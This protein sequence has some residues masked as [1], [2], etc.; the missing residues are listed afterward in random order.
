[1]YTKN[2]KLHRGV[3]NTIQFQ[4]LNQDQKPINLTGFDINFRLISDD[5]KRILITKTVS[6]NPTD[7]ALP[8][9]GIA[10]LKLLDTDLSS[11]NAQMACYSL[12]IKT[13][14][15]ILAGL[16]IF[17]D[18]NSGARG[19]I[20]ILNSV[21]SDFVPSLSVSIPNHPLPGRNTPASFYS[22][23]FSPTT[24]AFTIQLMYEDYSG[25]M[26]VQG[27]TEQDGGWYD[28][29]D[30]NSYTLQN[31]SVSYTMDYGIH[32]YI[33]CQFEATAGDVSTILVR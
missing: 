28:L 24:N 20:E 10:V 32:P 26:S 1:V 9:T 25:T 6:I 13:H 15:S 31:G 18:S 11:I 19:K 30:P 23:V 27:S 14:G 4:I 8:L 12:E 21:L 7:G 2:L 22:S 16:P 17:T 3:D 33:R 5:G 29:A